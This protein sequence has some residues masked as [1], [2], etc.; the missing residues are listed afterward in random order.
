MAAV[1]TAIE[2]LRLN[3]P[4]GIIQ[5]ENQSGEAVS[6]VKTLT[7]DLSRD[8]RGEK[9]EEGSSKQAKSLCQ[10]LEAQ[11]M[12]PQLKT[13]KDISVAKEEKVWNPRQVPRSVGGNI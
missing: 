8:T 5:A 4:V 9:M 7:Q 3:L 13:G 6:E 1:E 11:Q 12:R 10:E 2:A